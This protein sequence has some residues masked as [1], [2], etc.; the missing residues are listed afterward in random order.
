M[1][2]AIYIKGFKTFARPVRMPLGPGITAIVGPNGS[3]KSNITDAVLFAL[4]EQSPGVLRAGGMVDL[5]FAGS[6]ALPAANAAEV[7][8]VL[9]NAGGEISLPHRE[10][11][12][13][14]R[15]SRDGRTEYRV[16]GTRA[17]LADVR[18]VAGEAGLGRHSILRQGAVDAI[19]AGGAEA[20]RQ[21]LEE[22]AG[23]GVYRRRRTAAA[24]R[25]ENASRQLEQI[26][27]LEAELAGQLRRIER[28][29]EAA[30][31]YRRLE[32]RYRE[33]SLA[34]LH[35][36]VAGG[37]EERLRRQLEETESRVR[38]LSSDEERLQ[39]EESRLDGRIGALEGDLRRTEA[40]L[41][42]LEEASEAFQST[43][44]LL[45]RSLFRAGEVHERRAGRGRAVVRLKTTLGRLEEELS[46]IEEELSTAEERQRRLLREVDRRREEAEAARRSGEDLAAEHGRVR[47]EL[48]AARTRLAQLRSAG[49]RATL[50]E[51]EIGRLAALAVSVERTEPG[52]G[53]VVSTG[54]LRRRLEEF[55]REAS[56]R[57]GALA[58]ATGRSEAR[59]RSLRRSLEERGGPR[60]RLHQVIR[61]RPGFELAVEA[62]LG[63]L[64]GGLLARNV[65]EG[66]ELLSSA[67][68]VTVRLDAEGFSEHGPAPGIPLLR[69]VEILDPAYADA[70]ER[71]LGGVYVVEDPI[72]DRPTN[73][74]VAVT[75]GGLRLTRTSLSLPA[76][77]GVF[78]REAHL[79]SE[80]ARL[81]ELERGPGSILRSLR[82][83]LSNADERLAAL[84]NL[85]GR[86]SACRNRASSSRDVLLRELRR[87][88]RRARR[89]L[90]D[91]R[92][93]GMKLAAL[94]QEVGRKKGTLLALESRLQEARATSEESET[95]LAAAREEMEACRGRVR[96]LKEARVERMRRRERLL[97]ALRRLEA[98]PQ[99]T[100]ERLLS[101]GR[102]AAA[103][104]ARLSAAAEKRRGELRLRRAADSETHRQLSSE[105][106]SLGRRI[107]ALRA[108]LETA[109]AEAARLREAARR[110]R[111]ATSAALEEIREEWGATPEEARRCAEHN[112]GDISGE[113][114]QLARRLKHFGDVN[115]LALSQ[116]EELRERHAFVAGQRADAEEA[117]ASLNRIIHD[118]DRRIASTFSETFERV[119]ATFGEMVPRMLEGSSGVLDL[120]EEGVE[121]G[122][123]LGR[124]GWRSIRVLSGGERSLLALA[125]LFSILLSRGDSARTFCILDEAEA[126][127]D[128]L[129][130]ARFLSVV[131][132]QRENGQ[133]L[134]VTHQKRTM[135]AADVLYGTAQDASGAT[136]VV[137][138]RI[139]GD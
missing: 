105:Q 120:S 62:A 68:R 114:R 139:Q 18:A 126:A 6:E 2:S 44:G 109:R 98:G 1:L 67:E 79:A 38:E 119:R 59:I 50:G 13:S 61:A 73:G 29:A 95:R 135:A 74:Y 107:T 133:F 15:I 42:R 46:R 49:E 26:R 37:V 34:R 77:S 93:H 63:E 57:E 45:D 3:G 138:K 97:A 43:A 40:M 10:V 130:L 17:R 85:V 118:V 136:V 52:G 20:C 96:R 72:G 48:E 64:A 127:L 28:E 25:L 113:L 51:E 22:A 32:A 39:A 80:E 116:E 5:I 53:A 9:D 65:D 4:G 56:R 87:R 33:L 123:R 14:R 128:D 94:E 60:P 30:R 81:E 23:L 36:E 35:R 24:R 111:E 115:L 121:I 101:C 54:N 75:R 112:P 70:V 124:K 106:G 108:E 71:L 83:G 27:Q 76:G 88:L 91:S 66:M 7:T 47:A 21:A 86:L 110:S 69:C 41:G 12:I 8:L 125:F 137:S 117:A 99:K 55:G 89:A 131:D 134:L 132:S 16:A 82:Q 31:E 102:R 129:N 84:E 92:R 104:V 78:E 11:S 122:I 90:E 103:A 58:A 19:V 100:P